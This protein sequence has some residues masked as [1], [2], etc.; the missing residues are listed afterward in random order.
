MSPL[1][2]AGNS[3]E[4]EIQREV[5]ACLCSLSLSPPERVEIAR[6][7]VPSLVFLAQSGDIEAARQSVGA[8][9]NIGEDIETHEYIGKS[10]GGRCMI[11]LMRHNS[12]DIHR[13]ASRCIANLLTSFHHQAEIIQDG[14]PGLIHLATSSDPECQYNASLSFRKLSPNLRSHKGIVYGGGLKSMFFL[15]KVQDIKTRKCAASA[16]RDISAHADHKLTFAE[17]GGIDALVQLSRE[18]EIELQV[19]AIAGLRHL[20]LN[21]QLK[22]P[23]VEAGCLPPAVRCVAYATEDLQCQ[24]AGLFANCSENQEVREREAKRSE[25]AGKSLHEN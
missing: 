6:M 12:I 15:L 16:L 13:E 24:C 17:Q 4:L 7:C 20:T 14:L 2:S 18:K 19:L 1:A 8:L 9:A 10:G 11:A 3:T 5:S 21:D 22:R 25:I 23:C